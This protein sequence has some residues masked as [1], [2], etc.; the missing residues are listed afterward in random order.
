M[1]KVSVRDTSHIVFSRK[2]KTIKRDS[3]IG[4]RKLAEYILSTSNEYIP[5]DTGTLQKSGRITGVN[6]LS[7]FTPYARKQYYEHKTHSYWVEH[8]KNKRVRQMKLV[9]KK[10]VVRGV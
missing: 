10:Y 4:Q 7:W 9:Y 8:A 2:I 3:K 1:Y 6:V 5:I